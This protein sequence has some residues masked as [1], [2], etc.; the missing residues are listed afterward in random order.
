MSISL[1]SLSI[2]PRSP[3]GGG[4]SEL[5]I[6]QPVVVKLKQVK[7]LPGGGDQVEPIDMD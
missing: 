6:F 1:M 2:L 4:G 5:T 3:G 7:G